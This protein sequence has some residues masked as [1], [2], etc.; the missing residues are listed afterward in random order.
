MVR[1]VEAGPEGEIC[2]ASEEGDVSGLQRVESMEA[3]CVA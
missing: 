2:G 1:Y 3:D